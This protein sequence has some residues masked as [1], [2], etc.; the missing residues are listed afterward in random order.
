VKAIM[1]HASMPKVQKLEQI[2][3]IHDQDDP[4]VKAIFPARQ[5]NRSS[6]ARNR[7][8]VSWGSDDAQEPQAIPWER[9]PLTHTNA[10]C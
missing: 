1:A 2:K 8:S 10:G 9:Q 6:Q 5:Y 3:A 4:Q 7:G